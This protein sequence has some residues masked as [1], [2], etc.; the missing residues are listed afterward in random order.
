MKEF[1][2]ELYNDVMLKYRFALDVLETNMK[3]LINEH[4]YKYNDKFNEKTRTKRI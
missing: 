3:I 1:N 4:E 2:E